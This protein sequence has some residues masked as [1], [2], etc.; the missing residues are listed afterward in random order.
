MLKGA[1]ENE[2]DEE[3]NKDPE[4]EKDLRCWICIGTKVYNII[5]SMLQSLEMKYL[6]VTEK[7]TRLSLSI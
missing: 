5:H 1:K 2:E 4:E 6:I 3:R 7:M